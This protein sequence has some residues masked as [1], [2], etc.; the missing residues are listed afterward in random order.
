[1]LDL[2]GAGRCSQSRSLSACVE[3]DFRD[4]DIVLLHNI[5]RGAISAAMVLFSSEFWWRLFLFA[6]GRLHFR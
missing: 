3:I 1:M 2:L 5:G 6:R 4:I